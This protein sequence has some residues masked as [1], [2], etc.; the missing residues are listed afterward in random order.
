MGWLG[1]ARSWIRYPLLA[2]AVQRL[3]TAMMGQ[4]REGAN[5]LQQAKCELTTRIRDE[6]NVPKR[7]PFLPAITAF[8]AAPAQR[9]QTRRV[10]DDGSGSARQMSASV[11]HPSSERPDCVADD[12]VNCEPVSASNSLL[13]GKLTGNFAESDP[14]LRFRGPVSERI[15]WLPAEFPTQ[16]NRE[17]PNAYQ[18]IFFE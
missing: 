9:F 10:G 17:F 14:P 1:L 4:D 3:L 16:Q 2:N 8:H 18:G 13:T 6:S 15:Q 7:I 5:R 11:F 12:A